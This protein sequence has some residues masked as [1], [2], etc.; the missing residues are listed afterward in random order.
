[1][2]SQVRNES[3]KMNWSKRMDG[4]PLSQS[5]WLSSGVSLGWVDAMKKNL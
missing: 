5:I 3:C 2:S 4:V 1:M